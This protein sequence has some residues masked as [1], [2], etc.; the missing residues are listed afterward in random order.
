LPEQHLGER[1]VAVLLD[2]G[3]RRR[4]GAVRIAGRVAAAIDEHDAGDALRDQSGRLQHDA[5]AHAVSHQ[6][7]ALELEVVDER[8]DVAAV[9]LDGAFVRPPGRAAVSAQIA[10]DH[11]V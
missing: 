3:A 7:H 1:G 2:R 11:G 5:A 8:G 10:G 4:L 6:H 9:V